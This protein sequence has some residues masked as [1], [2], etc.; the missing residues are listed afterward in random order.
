MRA[1]AWWLL[2]MFGTAGCFSSGRE[3]VGERV[4][5]GPAW[6]VPEHTC[7]VGTPTTD[8][9]DDGA[10]SQFCHDGTQ[11]QGQLVRWHQ[12]GQ[13][14]AQGNYSNDSRTGTWTWWHDS[15][16]LAT[17]GSFDRDRE[18]GTWTW[19]HRSGQTQM[20]GDHVNG[21]RMGLWQTWY[22]SGQLQLT[23]HFRNGRKDGEWKD[24]TVDGE[25]A[26]T[27]V[28]DLGRLRDEN[29]LIEPDEER[30]DGGR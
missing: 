4:S 25:L 5:E 15:G 6:T 29:V 8:V 12:N 27:Q 23:G 2:C 19:W 21:Q 28:W 26:R 13:K 18:A 22:P 30:E 14:A 3:A 16:Q 1:A 24:F 17:R 7:A 20:R 11:L 9:G 10:I